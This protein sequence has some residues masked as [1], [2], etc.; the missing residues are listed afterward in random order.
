MYI[1][2]LWQSVTAFC[3]FGFRVI[4]DL[5]GDYF[6]KRHYPVIFLMVKCGILFEVK[7]WIFVYYLD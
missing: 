2:L 7:D 5:T 3:V 4:L 1:Q 6:L